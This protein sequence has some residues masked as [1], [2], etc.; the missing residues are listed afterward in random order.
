MEGGHLTDFFTLLLVPLPQT[1]PQTRTLPLLRGLG[2]HPSCP[3]AQ[4]QTML[5]AEPR[6]T[7]L[8]EQ[9]FPSF[10]PRL[11]A[12]FAVASVCPALCL[13]RGRGFLC[14]RP[15]L[16]ES[17]SSSSNLLSTVA[18]LFVLRPYFFP[19]NEVSML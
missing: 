10:V 14:S 11:V 2:G 15:R 5:S 8:F 7:C 18:L 19:H 16:R 9:Q 3:C 4:P 17:S 12:Q 6:T 13:P 1:L